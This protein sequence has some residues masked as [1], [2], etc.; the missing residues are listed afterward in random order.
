VAVTDP[1]ISF[2]HESHK[3]IDPDTGK[4]RMF[5]IFSNFNDDMKLDVDSPSLVG[6]TDPERG[7]AQKITV[8][9]PLVLEDGILSFDAAEIEDAIEA[10]ALARANADNVL[11]SQITT[12]TNN[13]ATNTANIA[14]NTANIATNTANIATINAR[15]PATLGNFVNDAAAAAGGVPV[16]RFY[17]NGSVV[18]VRVS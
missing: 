15:I 8:Q 4:P 10:E 13:V 1:A 17:R 18:M 9:E 3:E 5:S 16:G 14:T 12:N 2:S 11:Q 7:P 6:R